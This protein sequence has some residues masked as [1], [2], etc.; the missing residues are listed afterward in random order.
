MKSLSVRITVITLTAILISMFSIGAIGI[1]ATRK[2]AMENSR[3]ELL[4][5]CD[6]KKKSIEEYLASIEQSVNTIAHYA[7][8]TLD[9]LELV[10]GEVVGLPA[11][12]EEFPGR[13]WNSPQQKKLDE[14][15]QEY[16]RQ[17]EVIFNSVANHTNGMIAYYFRFNTAFS[18]EATGFLYSKV[19]SSSFTKIGLNEILEYDQ[20]DFGHVGWYY[21]P[22]RNG[23]PTWIGPYENLNLGSEM[24]S[25]IVPLYKAGTLIGVL[26]MDIDSRTLIDQIRDLKVYKTGYAFLVD[27]NAT[28][29]YHPI[30]PKGKEA[31]DYN[32]DVANSAQLSYVS[33][34]EDPI[35]VEYSFNG[36]K[37]IAACAFLSDGLEIVVTVPTNEIDILWK[38]FARDVVLLG[39]IIAVLFSII[40]WYFMHKVIR[41]LKNLTVVAQEVIE[42]NYDVNLTYD[43]DDEVGILTAS[44]QHLIDYLKVYISDLNS[45]AYTDSLTRVRNKA[46]FD[47]FSRKLD[48]AIDVARKEDDIVEFSVIMFDC[49]DL[50]TINDTFG[51]D[52]GD[53]YLQTACK[54]ICKIFVNSH[55]FRLGGDEFAAVLQD[56]DFIDREELVE[57]FRSYMEENNKSHSKPWMHI[58]VSMGMAD[59]LPAVDNNVKHCLKRA[60][61]LM[62]QEKRRYKQK[63]Y[64][65]NTPYA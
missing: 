7:N 44:F 24:I 9:T 8:E 28:V 36:V 45:K 31:K 33:R 30:F 39:V 32:I 48:N 52:K 23:R 60:D 26:G 46:G 59:Y 13:D 53:I 11:D 1:N 22:I 58:N 20:D 49:N 50:K 19:A 16:A 64:K 14:Y 41:P 15:L 10:D 40:S 51:H 18:K 5:V 21:E 54:A 62:Y 63:K 29:V 4:L 38:G 6:N 27:E 2:M 65:R 34:N 57:K 17:I 12:Q 37:K 35:L 61:M 55:V 56:D 47:I 42:G 43:G 25:Y 3:K